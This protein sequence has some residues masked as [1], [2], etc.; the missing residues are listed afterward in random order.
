MQNIVDWFG[1]ELSVMGDIVKVIGLA[2]G[3]FLGMGLV[4]VLIG[5]AIARITGRWK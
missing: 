2:G 4:G 3:V 1:T 5:L